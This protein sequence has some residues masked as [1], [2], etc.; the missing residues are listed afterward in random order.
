MASTAALAGSHLRND[1]TLFQPPVSPHQG[2]RNGQA[3]FRHLV[4]L[5]TEPNGN[6]KI[7]R[8][9][10]TLVWPASRPL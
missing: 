5:D 7:T 9:G 6:L 10:Q 1:N 8:N 2:W 4:Q 3:R